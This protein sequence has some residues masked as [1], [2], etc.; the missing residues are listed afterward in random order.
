M[1][2]YV[3]AIHKKREIHC[4]QSKIFIKRDA[5][6]KSCKSKS[7]IKHKCMHQKH[8]CHNEADNNVVRM[9]KSYSNGAS[10]SIKSTQS[11]YYLYGK[12]N[13]NNKADILEQ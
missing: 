4:K 13:N 7:I 10:F 1:L 8:W 11:D 3:V 2:K 9:Y 6:S 12:K 5:R